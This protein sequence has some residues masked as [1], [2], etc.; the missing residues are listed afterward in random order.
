MTRLTSQEGTCQP[1]NSPCPDVKITS[2]FGQVLHSTPKELQNDTQNKNKSVSSPPCHIS[3]DFSRSFDE[4]SPLTSCFIRSNNH[5]SSSSQTAVG[6][7][8]WTELVK[9][10][11]PPS[12]ENQTNNKSFTVLQ[13][14]NLPQ[15]NDNVKE[16]V[17]SLKEQLGALKEENDELKK[18]VNPTCTCKGD[19][20]ASSTSKCN[21]SIIKE[22]VFYI[23]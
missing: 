3:L 17:K 19:L 18:Q 23:F 8:Y 1:T 16:E 14:V 22:I 12:N 2:A 9:A 21:L 20:V 10:A 11:G 15:E 13:R 4:P 5:S 7:G 6:T